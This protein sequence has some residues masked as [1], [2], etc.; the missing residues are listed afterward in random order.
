MA[1]K[2]NK[3]GVEVIEEPSEEFEGGDIEDVFK[4]AELDSLQDDK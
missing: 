1:S 3:K 4:N 2:V